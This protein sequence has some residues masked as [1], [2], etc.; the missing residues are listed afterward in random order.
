M[1]KSAY[2]KALL[3]ENEVVKD[4]AR[5]E[6]LNESKLQDLVFN[7]PQCLPIS[8]I[9][10]SYN[11]L[12]PICKEL[13]TPVGPLDILMATPNGD[14]AIVETKLWSNPE[15]RRK[16]VAQILDYAN[17]L[18]KWNYE[19]LQREIN[20][21]L[22]SKGNNLYKLIEKI[23]P[24]DTAVESSFVDNVSRNLKKGKFLLLIV[25]DGIKE[26]AASITEFLS[27]AGHLNFVFGMIELTIYNY[28]SGSRIVLPKTISKTVELQKINIELPDG[29]MISSV[30]NDKTNK[31]KEPDPKLE[32][33]RKFLKIFWEEFVDE[34]ELDDPGQK[35]PIPNKTYNLKIYPGVDSYSWISAYLAP[36]KEEVGVYFQY[37]KDQTGNQIYEKVF[38]HKEEIESELGKEFNWSR[39]HMGVQLKITDVYSEA[40]R[41]E[42][43]DYF[44][45]WLN[46]FV[47]VLRPIIKEK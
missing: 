1:K 41:E 13:K 35:L 6:D 23:H 29:L 36:K 24:T 15:A 32:K 8:D 40:N 37:N 16:V 30:R 3:I 43:K 12:V 47:N 5:D 21:N 11:P 38:S 33:R 34:L 42:I 2:G 46:A 17:E 10:E 44:K 4:L 20:R 19:D 18:S 26:G 45:K 9:D 25:G 31:T 28:G 14:L 39:D 27:D 22:K 7:F